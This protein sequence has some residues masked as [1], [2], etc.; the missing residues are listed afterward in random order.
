MDGADPNNVKLR[1]IEAS[2]PL[3]IEALAPPVAVPAN[4]PMEPMS[5]APTPPHYWCDF[6]KEYMLMPDTLE[7]NYSLPSPTL[8]ASTQV[9]LGSGV[10][11]G[12]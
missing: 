5:P 6:C 4:I 2:V 11:G 9:A 1:A 10:P 12:P 3:I 8:I 7:Y